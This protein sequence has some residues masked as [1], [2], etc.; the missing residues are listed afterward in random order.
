MQSLLTSLCHFGKSQVEFFVQGFGSNVAVQLEPSVH[1]PPEY[2]LRTTIDQIA[3]DLDL[4][5]RAQQQRMKGSSSREMRDTLARADILAYRALEP[6]ICQGLIDNTTVVTYFQKVINVRLIPYAPVALIGLP[7]SAMTVSRDLL[8]IPHEVGHYVFRHGRVQ[9][10][11]FQGSRFDAAL[12]S[13][14]EDLPQWALNWLEEIFADVYGAL[15]GGPI[16]AL[17]FADLVTDDPVAEFTHDDGEHPVAALRLAIYHRV[18]TNLGCYGLELQGLQAR[19][20]KAVDQRGAPVSFVPAGG[21]ASITIEDAQ[22]V[23]EEM[24]DL[25]MA[26]DLGKVSADRSRWSPDLTIR[27]QVD[28]LFLGFAEEVLKLDPAVATQVPDV[29]LGEDE[30]GVPWLRLLPLASQ[31]GIMP[32]ERKAGTTGLWIDAIKDAKISFNMPPQ[33]WME[34]L[35]GSGWAVEG[36]GG[37]AHRRVR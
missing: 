16:M 1:Y 36:P 29:K 12:C 37:N 7:L 23:L 31:S 14:F 26:G 34:L 35:D 24:V 22:L 32:V 9:T 2:A 30:S 17:G 28:D 33:V 15:V 4:I 10:G 3:Y 8:A 18:F 20:H 11:N 21:T 19:W 13:Q 6:A 27:E 25:I 5:Q